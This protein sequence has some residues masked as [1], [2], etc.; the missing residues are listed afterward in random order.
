MT[1]KSPTK[2]ITQCYFPVEL[3]DDTASPSHI[4]A[5]VLTNPLLSDICL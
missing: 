4:L 1:W 3:S 2:Y 5:E